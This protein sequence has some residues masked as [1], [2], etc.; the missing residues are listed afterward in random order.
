M[1][2]THLSRN[3]LIIHN[4]KNSI[5]YSYDKLIAIY[6]KK[7]NT[8]L[9]NKEYFKY[10]KTTSKYLYMFINEYTSSSLMNV[11]NEYK[12]NRKKGIIYHL[13]NYCDVYVLD[14]KGMKT[15]NIFSDEW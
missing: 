8:I 5:Y 1:A 7:T 14:E 4:H 9:L 12:K 3:A 2:V 10:S 15:W 6:W 13:S 11:V